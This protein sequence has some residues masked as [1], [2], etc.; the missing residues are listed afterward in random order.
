MAFRGTYD[1]T[2]DAKNRLT[3]PVK[4]RGP[5]GDGVVLARGIEQCVTVWTPSGFDD[6]TARMIEALGPLSQRASDFRRVVSATAFETEIDSAGRVMLPSKLITHA[7]IGRE[8]AVI[9]NDEAFEV[10]DR[11]RWDAYDA[12]ISPT[13]PEL[14]GSIGIDG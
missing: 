6:W 2:L 7:A 11:T 10:W 8:V 3:V 4:F 12:S 5:L 13:L 9:G 14:T 1:H